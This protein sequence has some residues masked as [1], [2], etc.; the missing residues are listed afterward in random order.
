MCAVLDGDGGKA[1]NYWCDMI[2]KNVYIDFKAQLKCLKFDVFLFLIT[3]E[4]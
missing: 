1:S 2:F 3:N 4:V